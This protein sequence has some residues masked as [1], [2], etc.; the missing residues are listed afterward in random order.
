MRGAV[1]R[2]RLVV[3]LVVGVLTACAV[4]P[5]PPPG[6]IVVAMTNSALD[7]DP[8]VSADEASQKVHQLLYNTLVRIDD[9]LRIVPDVAESLE[10]PDPLTYIATLR[11]GVRFHFHNGRELTA[12]DAERRALYGRAQ[13]LIAD[14]LPYIPLWYRTNVV[15][16]QS[17]IRGVSLSPI[18]DF[19]FLKDVYRVRPQ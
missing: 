15:V 4:G 8:R 11:R 13:Q 17:D 12:A 6:A 18:A 9:N 7:L 19:A 1:W 3:I 10:Q 5:P 16:S 2:S 14:D